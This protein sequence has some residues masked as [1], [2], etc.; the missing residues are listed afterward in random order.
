[1]S[2]DAKS[3]AKSGERPAESSGAKAADK[4]AAKAPAVTA[5]DPEKNTAEEE[6]IRQTGETFAKAYGEGDASAVAAHFTPDAEYVDE[7][8]NVFQG[9]QAIEESLAAFFTENP[10]SQLEVTI[11]TIRFVSP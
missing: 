10:G 2:A 6:A 8:G 1:K 9:R 5:T 11:D 4:P 3:A 7:Q